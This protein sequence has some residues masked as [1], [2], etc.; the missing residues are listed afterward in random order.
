[1]EHINNNAYKLDLSREYQV[2]ATFN[3]TYLS[4]FDAGDDLR[5]NLF[6]EE[7]NDKGI[8]RRWSA[9]PLEMLLGPIT[10][11]RAKDSK[12][13]LLDLFKKS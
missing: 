10:R 6:Q 5:T 9:V 1:M 12:K 13:R 7:G 8:A 4:P 2:S 11:A 3:I